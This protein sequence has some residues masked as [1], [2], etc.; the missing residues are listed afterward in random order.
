MGSGSLL[1]LA[2]L[3]PVV[4]NFGCILVYFLYQKCRVRSRQEGSDE[5]WDD[6]IWFRVNTRDRSLFSGVREPGTVT[7]RRRSLNSMKYPADSLG[8]ERK[9]FGQIPKHEWND[10]SCCICLEEYDESHQLTRLPCGHWMHSE[11]IEKWFNRDVTCP[12]CKEITIEKPYTERISITESFASMDGIESSASSRSN[13][14]RRNSL[15]GSRRNSLNGSRRPSM[16]TLIRDTLDQHHEVYFMYNSRNQNST[17]SGFMNFMRN[18]LQGRQQRHQRRSDVESPQQTQ[19][20]RSAATQ[21]DAEEDSGVPVP[22]VE[23]LRE[24]VTLNG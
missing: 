7:P 24:D 16:S 20:Q 12:L 18:M 15:N 6:V 9:L 22:S 8:F 19:G 11:C 5:D 14:S 13:G 4:L 2:T 3:L 17:G 10:T 21:V 23:E 1:L